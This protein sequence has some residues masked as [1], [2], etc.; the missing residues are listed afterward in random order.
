MAFTICRIQKIKSWGALARSEA[1]TA[2]EVN[3][4]SANPQ[5]KNL[6]VVENCDNLDLVL[7]VR[8]K[9][10]SQKYRSDAV[11]TVEML[12]SASAE[13]FRPY[14]AHEGGNY[15]K[16]RLD[17]FVEAVVEWLD[18][19]WGDRIVKA[20][21]HLD[22]ITPHI[23]AYLVPLDERGKLNCKALFGTRVKMYQ[24]QDSFANA[25]EHLGIVRGVKGSVATHTKIKK[26]YAAVNQDSQLLDL[27]RYIPQPQ[28]REGSVAYRQRVIELLNPQLEVINYQLRERDRILQQLT[29]L[30]QTASVSEQL[31]Y[32]LENEVRLL[33]ANHERL[34]LKLS[35]VAYELGLNQYEHLG[36]PLSLVMS[37][38][39]CNFDDAVVW[40]R[41]RFGETSMTH[42]VS[43]SALTIARQ[44]QESIF[45]PPIPS[46]NHLLVVEDYLNQKHS[47]PQ[48]L[49]KSL[50]QRGLL[51][52]STNGNAVFIARNLDGRTTGA[53][54]YS[55]KNSEHEFSLCT[56]SR[57][58]SGWFHLSVG[59]SNRG[60]IETA[61][62]NSS[63]ID[64]LKI[65]VKNAPHNHRTLYLTLDNENA[66]L[67]SEFLKTLPNVV[68][69]L[70]EKRIVSIRK[71][72][73]N[74]NAIDVSEYNQQ[75][76]S[77]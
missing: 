39:K 17:D 55:L 52:A 29:E 71:I 24:L 77:Y 73:P 15:D 36:N 11:L 28:P 60:L 2:R 69:A 25:V 76:Q 22:E 10:G 9:I 23:H 74:A 64:A 47:I 49:L 33:R 14:A 42:A 66:P 38:N 21:L 48:K 46:H 75:Q 27:E 56:G 32:S 30:K 43:K 50:Q 53:Y 57:R 58:S 6:E 12:L 31:R 40:L 44:T 5:I 1:H 63:P 26:Y 16:Q 7:K 19:S 72:L 4:P 65:M 8:N 62:L 20:S 68:V 70:P 67:P 37:V 45:V 51:Y 35:E 34:D 54:L 3:T 59:G 13:Y 41:D 18:N 61:V